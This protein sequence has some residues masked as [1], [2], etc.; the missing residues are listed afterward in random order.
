MTE[1]ERV[2]TL[3]GTLS[4]RLRAAVFSRAL[5]DAIVLAAIF[6]L[7]VFLLDRFFDFRALTR[8]V[9]GLS[10]VT[11]VSAYITCFGLIPS[12]R[13]YRTA[14]LAMIAERSHPELNGMLI[15]A[16]DSDAMP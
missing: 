7:G 2:L 6:F 4:K 13:Q 8:V 11:G 3:L 15:T 14:D 9:L 5:A 12:L 1:R 16:V 10:F